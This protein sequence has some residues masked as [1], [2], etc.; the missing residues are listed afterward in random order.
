M[1]NSKQTSHSTKAGTHVKQHAEY[2]LISSHSDCTKAKE[3]LKASLKSIT[4][5]KKVEYTTDNLH[6]RHA[7]SINSRLGYIK[8]NLALITHFKIYC[9]L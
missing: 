8:R 3:Q 4:L 9:K 7:R 1:R 6:S 5:S 2:I